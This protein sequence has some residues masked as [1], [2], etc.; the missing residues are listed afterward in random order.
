MRALSFRSLLWGRIGSDVLGGARTV[1]VPETEGNSTTW[2][3]HVWKSAGERRMAIRNS[4]LEGSA[5]A[6]RGRVN[7]IYGCS[8]IG[9]Q[10]VIGSR[11]RILRWDNGLKC[12]SCWHAVLSRFRLC[13]RQS[14]ASKKVNRVRGATGFGVQSRESKR[15][16]WVTTNTE[17]K[18]RRVISKGRRVTSDQVSVAGG[19]AGAP[20]AG[21]VYLS[22]ST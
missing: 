22:G 2:L 9:S 18:F 14:G 4:D 21:F 7:T 1:N 6:R 5:V 3:G 11:R 20:H 16:L 13:A 12:R 10:R 8:N 17:P 15:S 19:G